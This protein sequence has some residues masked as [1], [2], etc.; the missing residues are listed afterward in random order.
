MK[1]AVYGTGG[2][3]GYF[4]GLL[5]HYEN[6]VT[7]IARGA[8][9]EAIRANGLQVFSTNGDF[10]IYPAEATDNPAEIGVVDYVIVAVKDY[11]LD[12]IIPNISPM[13]GSKTTVVPL[14]NGVDAH[15]RI[16][17]ELGQSAVV[18]GLCSIVSMIEA[19]GVIRQPSKLQR[20][21]VGELD[22]KKSERVDRL[23]DMWSAMG[24]DASQ[25]KDIYSAIWTKFVFIA[26]FGG[27]SSL[28]RVSMGKILDCP[29]TRALYREAIA[30]VV[31]LANAQEIELA[32]DIVERTMKFSESFEPSATSSMQRDV[33][34]GNPFELGAFSG[35][36]V[37]LGKK[38]EVEAPVHAAIY[39]LLKPLLRQALGD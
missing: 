2:V 9:L 26:S 30:E 7:F 15:E 1:I 27:V 28:A 36:I 37:S 14:L 21:R 10:H 17:H 39:A 3:G 12:Q 18:G 11:H 25:A 22:R 34:A 6:E 35:K 16:A 33:A 5:A 19:P 32:E 20:I 23:V 38:L 24:V 4:G 31:A 29:E 8:H 13:V